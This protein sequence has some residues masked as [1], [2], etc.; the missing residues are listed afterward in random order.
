MKL[1]IFLQNAKVTKR[2]YKDIVKHAN[3]FG[4]DFLILLAIGLVLS[5]CSRCGLNRLAVGFA[6]VVCNGVSVIVTKVAE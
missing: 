1:N 3:E 6:V 2:I 5:C 4:S